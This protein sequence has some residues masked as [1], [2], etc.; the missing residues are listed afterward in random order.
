[1]KRIILLRHAKAVAEHGGGDFA[2]P[3]APHG[4]AQI[5]QVAH[6]F[7]A[8]GW[9]PELALASPAARARETAE[10]LAKHIGNLAIVTDQTLYLATDR[11][12]TEVLAGM[13]DEIQTLLL[14]GHN[15]GISELAA[16]WNKQPAVQ[17]PTAGFVACQLA[18]HHWK[19]ILQHIPK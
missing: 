14:I 5:Q 3:L 2:R 9:K 15:P 8:H 13:P 17:L 7:Q 16:T 6:S 1:M 11:R 10:L 19:D 12:M 4:I 18:I